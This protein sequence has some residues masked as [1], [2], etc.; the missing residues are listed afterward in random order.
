M[1]AFSTDNGAVGG[2]SSVAVSDNCFD[3]LGI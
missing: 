3:Y 1:V 2:W